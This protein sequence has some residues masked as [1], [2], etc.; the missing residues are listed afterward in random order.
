[1]DYQHVKTTNLGQAFPPDGRAISVD[2]IKYDRP[3]SMTGKDEEFVV[4]VSESG[5]QVGAYGFTREQDAWAF[6][7][8]GPDTPYKNAGAAGEGVRD[9][10]RIPD[11]YIIGRV[12]DVTGKGADAEK[13]AAALAN[14]K[15]QAE[16][17][18][19]LSSRIDALEAAATDPASPEA[20]K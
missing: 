20:D 15:Q 19:K 2:H 12:A 14:T 11:G 10:L 3:H 17:I 16:L 5:Q 18:Q 1:M 6:V 9:G 4:T 13:L 8:G 7:N